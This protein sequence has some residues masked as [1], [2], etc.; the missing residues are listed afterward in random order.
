MVMAKTSMY[1][2]NVFRT[3]ECPWATYL[4]N[5]LLRTSRIAL[6]KSS[7]R[8][9]PFTVHP[10]LSMRACVGAKPKHLG[11][12]PKRLASWWEKFRYCGI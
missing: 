11:A 6:D 7:R 9:V 10:H 2:H 4:R 5:T 1:K 8:F 3:R 12:E